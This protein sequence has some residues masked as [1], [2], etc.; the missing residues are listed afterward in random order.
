MSEKY[1][2]PREEGAAEID[3]AVRQ[4]AR[5]LI[6]QLMAQPIAGADAEL[7]IAGL[8]EERQQEVKV[9]QQVSVMRPDAELTPGGREVRR[10]R[11]LLARG[12]Q[13]R[14]VQHALNNS[15]T[16][17]LAEAQLLEMEPLGEE[18]R[19]AVVRIIVLARRLVDV[20]R[21][22]DSSSQSIGV[23]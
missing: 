12:E 23:G 1:S 8:L 15:L 3:P 4:V 13:S 21:Q 16:A 5:A 19:G 7:L 14:T 6:A 17:L 18:Q 10:I 9:P 20:A 2:S 11:T 22:L